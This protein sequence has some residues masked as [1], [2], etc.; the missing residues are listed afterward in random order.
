MVNAVG[1]AA[2]VIFHAKA[3][4]VETAE[5]PL[6]PKSEM[7][8]ANVGVVQSAVIGNQKVETQTDPN[9][10]EYV[11]TGKMGNANSATTADMHT[12]IQSNLHLKLLRKNFKEIS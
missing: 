12:R 4:L 2:T 5:M 10:L 1:S 11:S 3:E 6:P 7:I 8:I 9:H